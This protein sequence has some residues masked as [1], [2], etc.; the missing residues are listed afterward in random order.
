MKAVIYTRVS[1]TEQNTDNQLPA[2]EALAKQRGWEVAEYY[3]EAESAWRNGHQQELARLLHDA[4]RHKFN[5]VL[6]WSLDRL[7][8]EGAASILNLVN[9]LATY[10]VKVISYQESWTEAPGQVADLLYAITG[11]VA[12]FESKRRSE[13]TKAGLARIKAQGKRLGRPPGS[14][15]RRKRIRRQRITLL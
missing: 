11:W 14:K 1:T 15:D 10:G 2:L 4:R 9:T 3:Q 6:C 7:T 12:E 13:R 8:R 5:I